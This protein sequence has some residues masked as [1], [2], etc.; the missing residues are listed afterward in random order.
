ETFADQDLI[1]RLTADKAAVA[2]E[3]AKFEDPS[4]RTIAAYGAQG[5][6]EQGILLLMD[7]GLPL[8]TPWD[9]RKPEAMDAD[10]KAATTALRDYPALRGWSWAANWWNIKLGADQ[11]ADDT[12]KAAYT[13][14]LAAAKSTGKW[15]PVLDTI[16]ARTFAMKVDAEARFRAAANSAAPGLVSA[17]TGPYR[18]PQTP[19]QVIFAHADEVDLHFQC[20]QT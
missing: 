16:A 18:A 9:T 12:E 19:P 2:P 4:R 7:A 11:A 1:T 10:V 13:A 20:E 6:E 3:K 8:G 14:A 5:M 15:D 17:L